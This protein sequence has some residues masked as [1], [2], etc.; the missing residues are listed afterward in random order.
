MKP[1]LF[2]FVIIASVMSTMYSNEKKIFLERLRQEKTKATSG[3]TPEEI[4]ANFL[5]QFETNEKKP[6]E[7]AAKPAAKAAAVK[8]A[9]KSGDDLIIKAELERIKGADAAAAAARK[10]ANKETV[11][12][13]MKSPAIKAAAAT[14]EAAATAARR[15]AEQQAATA[16][17]AAKAKLGFFAR[18]KL[19]INSATARVKAFF[20]RS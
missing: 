4:Q 18:A 16:E 11:N 17:A 15:A 20:K 14:A 3:M 2:Y 6:S 8:A 12:S 10:A 5:K 13:L 19:N 9:A 1:K 7:T